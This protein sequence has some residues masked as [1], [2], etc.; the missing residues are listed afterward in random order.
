MKDLRAR[1]QGDDNLKAN[2]MASV[3]PCKEILLSRAL[4]MDYAGNKV[5]A[6]PVASTAEIN[7][8]WSEMSKIDAGLLKTMTSAD[9]WKTHGDFYSWY[10]KHSRTSQYAFQLKNCGEFPNCKT[11]LQPK[12]PPTIFKDLHFLPE[13]EPDPKRPGSYKGFGDV[14]RSEQLNPNANVPTIKDGPVNVDGRGIFQL[15]NLKGRIICISCHKPRCIFG[16]GISARNWKLVCQLLSEQLHYV[17]G[18]ELILDDIVKS[19]H[20][21]KLHS[22]PRYLDM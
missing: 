22:N 20:C 12:L 17:C 3:A 4:Q 10:L 9:V 5:K 16:V 13:P 11:C 18:S 19:E 14:Y 1:V 15:K 8:I 2:V 21:G 6:S 7:E